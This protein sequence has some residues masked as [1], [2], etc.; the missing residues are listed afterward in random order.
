MDDR[1]PGRAKELVTILNLRGSGWAGRGEITSVKL[2][3]LEA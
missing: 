3:C 1:H 2:D